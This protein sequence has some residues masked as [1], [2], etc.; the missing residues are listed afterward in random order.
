MAASSG[1]VSV[2]IENIASI[3][4]ENSA[5][6]EEVSAA[7]EEMNAQVEEVTASAQSLNAMAEQL[8][9]LIAQFK[10]SD[11][12]SMANQIEAFKQCHVRW[13][14]RL[15]DVVNGKLQMHQE[16][17]DTHTECILG[18]W[19]TNRGRADYGHLPEFQAIERPHAQMHQKVIDVVAAH[20]RG[21]KQAAKA[22]VAEVDK[23]SQE[24]VAA[25]NRLENV[26]EN[27][28]TASAPATYAVANY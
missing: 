2:A 28:S 10:F 23:L 26:I 17:V 3:S 13:V 19:Y 9:A 20:N 24:V 16:D 11:N 5:A 22:G 7:T 1:E 6:A 21:D 15:H 12:G 8:S 18:Q 14:D 27:R 4:E 25:L